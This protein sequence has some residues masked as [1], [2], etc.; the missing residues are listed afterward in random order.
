MKEIE[1]YRIIIVDDH[2]AIVAGVKSIAESMPGLEI[3]A[4]YTD[5]KQMLDQMDPSQVDLVITDFSMNTMTGDELVREIK[6]KNKDIKVITYTMHMD[7]ITI[8]RMMKEGVDGYIIKGGSMDEIEKAIHQVLSGR[9]YYCE[10]VQNYM[11]NVMLNKGTSTGT[12]H[13]TNRETD[14]LA[15][16]AKEYTTKEIAAELFISKSTV[17]TYRNSLIAKFQVKNSIGLVLKAKEVNIIS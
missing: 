14:I 16:I 15:L 13:L 3:L 5:P 10:A 8:D 1:K 4:T 7:M 12:F 11:H 17:E 2:A 6:Q 9:K